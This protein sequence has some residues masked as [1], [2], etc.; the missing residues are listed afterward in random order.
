[1]T[2][3]AARLASRFVPRRQVGAS[4][5][6]GGRLRSGVPAERCGGG[7]RSRGGHQGP[8]ATRPG[9][10]CGEGWVAAAARQPRSRRSSVGTRRHRCR[11]L[12]TR[13]RGSMRGTEPAAPAHGASSSRRAW[14]QRPGLAGSVLGGSVGAYTATATNIANGRTEVTE[15]LNRAV[16]AGRHLDRVSRGRTSTP[17]SVS[18]STVSCHAHHPLGGPPPVRRRQRGWT[19]PPPRRSAT[20]RAPT[21]GRGRPRPRPLAGGP[22]SGRVGGVGDDPRGSTGS[23]T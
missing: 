20:P 17:C 23:S 14:R 11:H 10:S 13:G 4:S 9:T 8:G 5:T 3:A 22:G 16:G 21:A 2:T 18:R 7:R 15:P 12:R 6:S 19:S 1:M